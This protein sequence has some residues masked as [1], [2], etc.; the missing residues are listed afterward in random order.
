M[1]KDNTVIVLIVLAV[2]IA[3]LCLLGKEKLDNP[4][5][6]LV[7]V[8]FFVYGFGAVGR[9]AG[10]KMGSPGLVSFFGGK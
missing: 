9:W 6:F 1:Q 8:A 3:G 4:L 7:M 2:I 5:F 10:S